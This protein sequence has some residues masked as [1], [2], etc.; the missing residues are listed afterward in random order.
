M[1]FA[2]LVIGRI[3]GT[4]ELAQSSAY[5]YVVTA[6]LAVGLYG[7]TSGIVV[8]ELRGNLRTVLIAVTVGV[9]AKAIIIA[10]VMLL[11]VDEPVYAL[12]LGVAVAQIDPLSVAA[13]VA[14]KRMSASAKTVLRAW[15]SFDDPVTSIITVYLLAIAATGDRAFT[16]IAGLFADLGANLLF[17]GV[18]FVAWLVARFVTARPAVVA[19]LA[20]RGVR[21]AYRT[22]GVLVLLGACWYAVAQF[23]LFGLALIGLFL[24]PFADAVMS[25]LTRVALLLATVALGLLL[26]N[27]VNWVA[28]LVLG[29]AAYG[30]QVVLAPVVARGHDLVDRTNLALGQQNGITAIT[31]A[32]LVEP[33]F[34]GTVGIIAPAILTVNV[35]HAVA[36]AAW[37]DFHATH[38]DPTFH[39][40]AIRALRGE[41][42]RMFGAPALRQVLARPAPPPHRM[43]TADRPPAR[44]V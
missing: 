11:V 43:R 19:L 20:H 2:G 14:D 16:G 25:R 6:L 27:G 41:L 31:L 36:T 3:V 9:I 4:G 42:Q 8:A 23:A 37:D 12:L 7:A 33:V 32:L 26:A 10:S 17:A 34:P 24:R 35:L 18:V 28:G 1:A 29:V 21:A 15:A 44:S 30:A 39:E 22:A 13:I 5:L 40:I 38:P